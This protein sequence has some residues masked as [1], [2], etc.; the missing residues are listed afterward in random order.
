M[1]WMQLRMRAARKKLARVHR[2]RTEAAGGADG[3]DAVVDGAWRASR[4]Q[5]RRTR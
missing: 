2:E 4:R 1:L 3:V 5:M